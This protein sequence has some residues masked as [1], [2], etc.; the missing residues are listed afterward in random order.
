M[1]LWKVFL[2]HANGTEKKLELI[3]AKIYYGGYLKI[4]RSYFNA[5]IKAIKMTKKYGTRKK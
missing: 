3:D 5:L 4:K 2:K 1:D